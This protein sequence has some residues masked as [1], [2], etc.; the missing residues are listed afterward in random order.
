M[1]GA[2]SVPDAA[3]ER[4]KGTLVSALGVPFVDGNEV[5]ILKNGVEIFPAML[6]AIRSAE[7]SVDFL[8]FV[9]WEGEIADTFAQALADAAT[10]GARV[11][12]LLDAIGAMRMERALIDSM[13]ACGVDVV[14]FRPTSRWT[15]FRKA[16]SR[17]H[18]KILICDETVGFTGGVGIGTEWEGDAQEPGSWRETH[19][20]LT[21]PIVSTLGSAFLE[22]WLEAADELPE[23]PSPTPA[24]G[25]GSASI[26]LHRTRGGQ[27]WSDRATLLWA[28]LGAAESRVRISTPYFILDE[29]TVTHFVAAAQRGVDVSVLV[30]GPHIDHRVAQVAGAAWYEDLLDAGVRLFEYQPTMIHQKVA[31][32]DD[33]ISSIGSA[34]LNQRSRLQ[35]HEVQ[36]VVANRPF[37]RALSKMLDEDFAKSEPVRPGTWRK[38]PLYRRVAETLTWPFRRQL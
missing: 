15:A 27:E 21:G 23:P 31:V 5:E 9:Y 18:R 8:T 26:Q 2:A 7:R 13:E 35:D 38:R 37:A 33:A 12:V 24:H 16:S 22:D 10:R 4:F 17:T 1:S 25:S 30:P 3:L 14:W 19:F 20:R 11:R 6:D 32:F 36:L 29:T 28:L 34:N